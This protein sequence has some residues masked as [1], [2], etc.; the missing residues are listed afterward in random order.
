MPVICQRHL[1]FKPWM[2][3][4]TRKLPGIQPV[5]AGEW[6]LRDEA[7]AAQMALRDRLISRRRAKVF[8]A[9]KA[10]HAAQDELLALV[11]AALDAGYEI[12]E[13][14]VKRPDG[15]VVVL[16]AQPPI[17]TAARLVQEDLLLLDM[18]TE[19]VLNAAVLCFPASWTLAEKFGGGLVDIHGY[20]DEYT[21]EMAARVQRMFAA[22]RPEQPLWRANFLRYEN[23]D[24]FQ[25]RKV[26]EARPKPV[27]QG[28][29][30]R[31]ERQTLR[32]LPLSGAVVFGI[33]TYVVPWG[34]LTP[35][36]QQEFI[37][38]CR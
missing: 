38:A 2:Q 17:L 7:F 20:V 10:S 25:P 23:A 4:K 32:K 8:K 1:P 33:H 19:P 13:D 15:V 6:L 21:D 28:G 22:I 31:V 37:G 5:R 36:E 35:F 3:D 24:L 12:G 11:L 27:E 26:G 30:V 18:S 14:R 34:L 16:G 29:F 9:G